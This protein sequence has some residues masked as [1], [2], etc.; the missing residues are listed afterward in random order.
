[1]TPNPK[2]LE[3]DLEMENRHKKNIAQSARKR[4]GRRRGCDF[5][6][7]TKSELKAMNGP[8]TT[9]RLNEPMKWASFTQ[10]PT[11]IQIEYLRSL[12]KRFHA[13][14]EMLP[15]L[16]GA[17]P[18]AVRYY[19]SSKGL[20]GVMA[21]CCE[22]QA[23]DMEGWRSFTNRLW[24]PDASAP[25]PEAVSVIPVDRHGKLT[26]PT[27]KDTESR[28]EL[29]KGLQE[30]LGD[31]KDKTALAEYLCV[32]RML[33]ARGLRKTLSV[34]ST[35]TLLTLVRAKRSER[36]RDDTDHWSR[37]SE[38][39]MPVPGGVTISCASAPDPT[40]VLSISGTA[41]TVMET[42]KSLLSRKGSEDL[43]TVSIHLNTN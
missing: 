19:L 35:K 28:D 7:R 31:Y 33:V 40:T 37:I 30:M 11:R 13:T 12:V 14:E 23:P 16:F 36:H 39:T 26:S 3:I 25:V 29:A 17:T 24:H 27:A 22:N 15:S 32:S 38:V 1:M 43:V 2:E 6:P 21:S 42:I 9:Y 4:V 5:L 41:K 8:C 20:A 18:T 10:I 34:N